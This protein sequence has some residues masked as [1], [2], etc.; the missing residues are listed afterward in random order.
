L[1]STA[2]HPAKSHDF[3]YL[4]VAAGVPCLPG[5]IHRASRQGRPARYVAVGGPFDA[6]ASPLIRAR[7]AGPSFP[8]PN[9]TDAP[10]SPPPSPP[11]PPSVAGVLASAQTPATSAPAAT[12]KLTDAPANRRRPKPQLEPALVKEFVAAGHANLPRVKEMLSAEP[13]C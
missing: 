4:R 13:G 7:L 5:L 6:F 12:P 1:A 10:S 3:G 11:P 9:E 8:S 2:L